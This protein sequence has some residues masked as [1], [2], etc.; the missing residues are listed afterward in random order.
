MAPVRGL[1]V[2]AGIATAGIVGTA[3]ADV[4]I[5]VA[6]PITG[7]YA[8]FGEQ[9]KR[10]A[11]LA[12][13]DINATG[14]VN[15]QPLSLTIA[16]D[17]CDPKQAV[18]VASQLATSGV[19]FVDGHYC[20]GSSIPASQIYS[21][22]GVLEIS[23]AS[24]SSK[25][26]EQGLKNVFRTCGRDDVQG[27]FT[28]GYIV[29]NQHA[30][31]VAI[32]HD[33]TTFGKGL[34]DEVKRQLNKRGA[35]E[36]MY[37]AISQG[38][39]DFSA[40][41]TKMKSANIDLVYYGG[42]H[43]E[44]GLLVRQAREQGLAAVLMSGSALVDRQFWAITGPTGEGTLITFAPDARKQPAAA[45]AVREFE[46]QGYAPE[47]FTL[48]TYAAVQ[49]FAEAARRAGSTQLVRLEQALHGGTYDTVLGPLTFDDKGDVKDFRY[50][51][52]KWHDG[53][54]DELYCP[55]SPGG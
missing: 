48:Y 51:V 50:C 6:G 3:R 29:D 19:V 1:C 16:D 39:R 14:G 45:G 34:A 44:A 4:R 26:T 47:G 54:Y 41:I 10:G 20:S 8:A 21:E 38:D 7:Q 15:G 12:V 52:Y 42:Y 32:V 9:M 30:Q 2:A 27:V 49:V 17:A 24:N 36:A 13:K 5:A 40:L 37:E 18:A 53:R 25:L 28:A 46:A 22:A 43:T 33:Q 31:R 23:P 11:E 55:P 35:Q